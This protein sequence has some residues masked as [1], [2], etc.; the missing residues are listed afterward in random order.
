MPLAFDI[1]A[2]VYFKKS[3]EDQQEIR[4]RFGY[5]DRAEGYRMINVQSGIRF[6]F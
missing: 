1:G 6:G 3:D 2:D 5:Y 4:S